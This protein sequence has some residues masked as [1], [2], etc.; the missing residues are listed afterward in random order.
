MSA[1]GDHTGSVPDMVPEHDRLVVV[2]SDIEMGSGG[3]FDDFPHSEFLGDL[4]LSC[5]GQARRDAAIDFVFNGDTFDLLKTPYL[6]MHPHHITEDIAL[7]KV[8]LVAANQVKFFEA[9]RRILDDSGDRCRFHFVVGNHDSELL[10]PAVQGFIRALCDN[11][12]L[13]E[14]PGFEVMI[15][16]VFCEHGS[17]ADPMFRIDPARLFIV[18][19]GERLL[20]VSWATV[21]LLDVILPLQPLLYF[22]D[23]LKPKSQIMAKIPEIR[24][25][26]IGLSWKY[27][28]RDFWHDLIKLKDP[29]LKLN[30]TMFK[31]I[32]RRFTTGSPEVS[33]HEDWL[34]T[35]VEKLDARVFC[36]GHL[37]QVGTSYHGPKRVIR[38]GCFRDEYFVNA[39][40]T[41]FEPILKS[42][43]QMYVKGP[44]VTAITTRDIVG[45]GRSAASFPASI[46]DVVPRVQELLDE[47]GYRDKEKATQKAQELAEAEETI[48]E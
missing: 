48:K 3:D 20:N 38:L 28:T 8:A 42:F 17:Q 24:E 1:W 2:F 6:G 5:Y 35:T 10:F 43:C 33:I 19:E 22:H 39:D 44:Q 40:G 45:P 46:Y 36:T 30:W 12:P 41:R 32:V 4:L 9:I 14:F 15:G 27:W 23:R 37:H 16:P 21:A 18:H 47:L 11:S 31:E 25:L 29:V 13:I 26:L 34:A 7:A